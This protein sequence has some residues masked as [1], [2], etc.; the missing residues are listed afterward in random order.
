MIF[1]CKHDDSSWHFLHLPNITTEKIQNHHLQIS[2][3]T[4]FRI[5]LG[6]STSR[7]LS[8]RNHRRYLELEYLQLDK[9]N[10]RNSRTYPNA[11]FVYQRGMGYIYIYIHMYVLSTEWDRM[12]D[13]GICLAMNAIRYLNGIY[14]YERYIY[15]IQ[16]WKFTIFLIGKSMQIIH[17]WNTFW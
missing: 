5:F 15:N 3:H 8:W 1:A 17:K 2:C 9:I 4:F 16:L 13:D 7:Q 11:M 14:S 10:A 12:G 6:A